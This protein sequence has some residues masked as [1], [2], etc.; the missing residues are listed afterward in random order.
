MRVRKE[1]R[2]RLMM[3]ASAVLV[4]IAGTV[5]SGCSTE[6]KMPEKEVANFKGGPPPGMFK[7]KT[8]PSNAAPANAGRAQTAPG[9]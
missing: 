5:L 9:K 1:S 7:D 8:T 6:N 2:A 3:G 4:L